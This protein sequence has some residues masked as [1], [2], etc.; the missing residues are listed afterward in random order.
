MLIGVSITVMSGL[1]IIIAGYRYLKRPRY[2][3]EPNPDAYYGDAAQIEAWKNSK[4]GHLM[5]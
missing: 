5:N 2:K 3:D 4:V 1:L